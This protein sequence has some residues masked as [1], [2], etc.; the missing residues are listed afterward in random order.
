MGIENFTE[1]GKVAILVDGMF[2]STGKGLAAGYIF[3]NNHI[4]IA[5][6]SLSP[7]AGHTCYVGGEKYLVKQ[8]PIAGVLSKRN[9]IYITADSVI[10]PNILLAE[11][12]QYNID[13]GRLA[14]HPRAAVVT[15]KL[16]SAE[17]SSVK[18]V[19]STLSGTGAARAA[20]IMRKD[21]LAENHPILKGYCCNLDMH[22]LL[23]E[24]SSVFV[25]TG[26]GLDLGLNFGYSYPFCTSRDILPSC[27]LGG[28]GVHPKYM[29]NL[30]SVIRT[31]PIRVGNIVERGVEVGKSGPFWSDSREISWDYLGVE[32]ERT[33]VTNRIRRVATFSREGY[34]NMLNRLQPTHIFLNFVNYL[35]YDVDIQHIQSCL[36]D[37][38][39]DFYS[40]GNDVLNC[41][42]YTPGCLERY[43]GV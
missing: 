4:D 33:T 14:I 41:G 21:V 38:M 13:P 6:A 35:K 27:I 31:F 2:G 10:D 1:P 19:A 32:A 39:P 17:A 26:Q 20:K 23:S 40:Y 25:E 42:V 3:Q 28:L 18:R 29:G 5:C 15:D 34:S 12:E 8:L 30:M 7:N 16:R 24:G 11:I 36:E 37:R 22:T 9:T 43:L